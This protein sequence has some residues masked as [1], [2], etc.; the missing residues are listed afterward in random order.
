MDVDKVFETVEATT[1]STLQRQLIITYLK[2]CV[3]LLKSD[4]E[5]RQDI[6]YN[7][8]GL[9]ATEYA[10]G[11]DEED[12]LLITLDFAAELEEADEQHEDWP[13]LVEI[14]ESLE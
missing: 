8:V 1:D 10:Q 4:P 12:P 14:I 11:L 7:I 2:S 13:L 9:S 5:A 6:A 3:A